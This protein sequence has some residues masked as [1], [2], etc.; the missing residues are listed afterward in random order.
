MPALLPAAPRAAPRSPARR[1]ATAP[2]AY[3]APRVTTR[4]WRDADSTLRFPRLV[5][6]RHAGGARPIAGGTRRRLVR[7]EDALLRVAS[8]VGECASRGLAVQPAVHPSAS[9][10]AEL[11]GRGAIDDGAVCGDEAIW[12]WF[13]HAAWDLSLIHILR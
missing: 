11:S 12:G 8:A 1:Q 13:T 6:G 2:Q 5:L 10:A 4:A 9:M 7:E 3:Q